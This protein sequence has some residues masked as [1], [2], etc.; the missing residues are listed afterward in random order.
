[1]HDPDDPE[2]FPVT[3]PVNAPTKEVAVNAPVEELK[4]KLVPVLGAKSPVA[5]VVYKTLHSFCQVYKT[6]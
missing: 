2:A 5:A 3:F 6:Q 1:M 4:V